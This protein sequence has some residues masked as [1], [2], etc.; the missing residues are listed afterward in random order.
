MPLTADHKLASLVKI[1]AESDLSDGVVSGDW[2]TDI[3]RLKKQTDKEDP[4][5][6]L[7]HSTQSQARAQSSR[8]AGG[9]VYI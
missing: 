2:L 6:F 7:Q 8:L 1:I 5:M 9:R 3:C 4:S